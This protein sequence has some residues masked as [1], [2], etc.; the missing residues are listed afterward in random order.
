MTNTDSVN[1]T[2]RVQGRTRCIQDALETF[3]AS[4]VDAVASAVLSG[5]LQYRDNSALAGQR[6]TQHRLRLVLD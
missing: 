3:E 4:N 6:T 2:T 5:L 1:A